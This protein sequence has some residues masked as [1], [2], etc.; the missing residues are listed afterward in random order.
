MR[1]FGT[2]GAGR[3]V[4]VAA[5]AVV[6]LTACTSS[7]A[8]SAV[9]AQTPVS[10][11]VGAPSVAASSGGATSG[12]A[13]SGIVPTAEL[14]T[15]RG[16]VVLPYD[17]FVPDKVEQTELGQAVAV[18]NALCLREAGLDMIVPPP[19]EDVDVYAQESFFGPWTMDQAQKF[20]FARPMR[21]ADLRANGYVPAD[22]GRPSDPV[23]LAVIDHDTALLDG[24]DAEVEACNEKVQ[25]VY[26]AMRSARD[27]PWQAEISA[28]ET[29]LPENDVVAAA[30]DDL[31]ACLVAGG[32]E[33]DAAQPG[34]VVGADV[35]TIDEEQVELAVQVVGCKDETDFTRRVATEWARLQAA[36]LEK[37]ET[38]VIAQGAANDEALADGRATVAAHPEVFVSGA[39]K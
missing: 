8:P 33:P 38:D 24:H 29:A 7:G 2:D 3:A 18:E 26:T 22:Y 28:V 4:V 25:H 39:G 13:A 27:T 1:I 9:D 12:S 32:L 19:F 36:V 5:L 6:P 10:S 34:Y 16:A 17:R 37:Y 30:F 31:D 20:G 23:A 11:S 35:V 21:D 15:A 14:D